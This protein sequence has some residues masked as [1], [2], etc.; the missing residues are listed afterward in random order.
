MTRL[1]RV[2]IGAIGVAFSAV[3]LFCVAA[4]ILVLV[5]TQLLPEAG[6]AA[7]S[8][9]LTAAAAL[10]AA[11]GG[12]CCAVVLR[13]RQGPPPRRGSFID[14]TTGKGRHSTSG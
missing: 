8:V 14:L 2:F 11:A 1:H 10:A 6:D 4:L 5:G 13:R 9:V 3:G 7:G 12:I